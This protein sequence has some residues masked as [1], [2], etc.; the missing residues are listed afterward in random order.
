VPRQP[1]RQAGRSQGRCT[2]CR[3]ERRTEIETLHARGVP[4]LRL[5]KKYNLLTG[6]IINHMRRH[7]SDAVRAELCMGDDIEKLQ[8]IVTE[9]S[10]SVLRH[11]ARVRNALY[12]SFDAA[13]ECADRLNTDRLARALHE[14]FRDVAR[15][16]GELSRSPL[17]VQQNNYLSDPG[18]ARVVAA[19]VA[20]VAPFEEAR[21][22]VM[23]ALR[24]LE[25]PEVKQ[26][27]HH[28]AA[29]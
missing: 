25:E 20:A 13:G 26:I 17:L 16:T 1:G 23:Q 29:E 5:G 21:V 14:N 12:R 3:H 28:V 6:S 8:E 2:V 15:I 19:I 4:A 24:R 11:Y 18:N 22:A 9:E 7:V 27:E 10:G